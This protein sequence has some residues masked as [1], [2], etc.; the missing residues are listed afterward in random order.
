[1]STEHPPATIAEIV[2]QLEVQLT[3]I[4]QAFAGH[5]D[6]E[7]SHHATPDEWCAKQ[8]LGH[9]IESEGEVFT[10]LIPGMIGRDAPD[11]WQ[12]EP[13]MIREECSADAGVL[14]AQW[15]ALRERGIA[16]ART[17]TDADLPRTSDLNWH[18]GPTEAV[19]DLFR[20]W[21]FHTDAHERQAI[22]VL[23]GVPPAATR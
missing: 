5:S 8:I 4:P 11:G 20:H 16:L 14:L 17:L 21:P 13:N 1:M 19:G 22:E 3:R 15:R 9:L 7:L 12:N 6:A 10:M 23:R 18:G 2:H